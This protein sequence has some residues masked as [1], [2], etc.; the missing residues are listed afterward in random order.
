[1]VLQP[2]EQREVLG[3]LLSAQQQ[4]IDLK[5]QIDR[6]HLAGEGFRRL[7]E[8]AI[9]VD[10]LAALFEIAAEEVVATFGTENAVVLRI[11]PEGTTV[12][13]TCCADDA[14]VAEIRAFSAYFQGIQSTRAC[15]LTGSDLPQL[16]GRA[17][18]VA[19]AG[20]YYDASDAAATYAVIATV[21]Q[22]KAP[23]YPR[24]DAGLTPLYEAFLH[25]VGALQQHLRGRAAT[26]NLVRATQH[27]VPQEFLQALGHADVTTARLGDAVLREITIVF[28]DIR[29]FTSISERMSPAETAAFLNSCLSRMGPHIRAHGG[30]IDKFI[31][32]AI[33]ALFPGSPSDAVRAALDM[34]ADIAQT[35]VETP[36]RAQFGKAHSLQPVLIGVGVHTGDVMMCTIGERERFEAT[37]ISDAVNLTARLETL[38][39]QL[40]CTMLVSAAVF[41]H[42]DAATR[43]HARELGSFAVKGKLQAARVFEV[44]ATDP[45]DL[46]LAKV[47]SRESFARALRHYG[48]GELNEA[49]A[50]VLELNECCP[51]DGPVAW[52]LAHMRHDLANSIQSHDWGVIHLDGK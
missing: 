12:C 47:A 52:W 40:G 11:G 8:R 42:L 23:F 34:Q 5:G 26:L 3:R 13:A 35:L 21:S 22:S 20:T 2:I 14:S 18:A 4:V 15:V 32:D 50:I 41:A 39:K 36:T 44:F 25:H 1:V 30:F 49:L 33:M 27:F 38:T 51:D 6:E 24:F 19:L 9:Q 43:A 48:R 10:H 31:G 29:N 28:A 7:G 16:R 17:T 37:V 46:R 45:V